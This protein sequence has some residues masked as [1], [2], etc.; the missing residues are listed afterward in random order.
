M[1]FAS[2][3]PFVIVVFLHILTHWRF[4]LWKNMYTYRSYMDT[5]ISAATPLQPQEPHNVATYLD[6]SLLLGKHLFGQNVT[7]RDKTCHCILNLNKK[8]DKT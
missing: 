5:F 8:R 6:F 4:E 2:W 7:N 1:V 3:F